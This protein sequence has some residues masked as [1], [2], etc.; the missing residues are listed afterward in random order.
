MCKVCFFVSGGWI[1]R[2]LAGTA[3]RLKQIVASRYLRVHSSWPK[4]IPLSFTPPKQYGERLHSATELWSP[5]SLFGYSYA[6]FV[7]VEATA[8]ANHSNGRHIFFLF[9]LSHLT[10]SFFQKPSFADLANPAAKNDQTKSDVSCNLLKN[11][12]SR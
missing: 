9:H 4:T 6:N 5:S 7:V 11:T 8:Y 10:R 3:G 12:F 2:L 1:C